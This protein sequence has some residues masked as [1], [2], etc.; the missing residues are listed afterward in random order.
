MVFKTFL[1]TCV[2]GCVYRSIYLRKMCNLKLCWSLC[3]NKMRLKHRRGK[4]K[5]EPTTIVIYT[6][7]LPQPV[8]SFLP[9]R[10]GDVRRNNRMQKGGEG[11]GRVEEGAMREISREQEVGIGLHSS[12]PRLRPLLHWQLRTGDS[13]T[14]ERDAPLK[15]LGRARKINKY[16]GE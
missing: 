4:K 1:K 6:I 5:K 16:T 12:A 2:F 15:R 14:A 9:F 10:Q 8:L 7:P 11:T 3:Q 13:G